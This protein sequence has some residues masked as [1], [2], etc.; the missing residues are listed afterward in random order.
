MKEFRKYIFAI[1]SALFFVLA[2]VHEHQT[3]N[4]DQEIRLI[5]TFQKA[6]I[7]QEAK[8]SNYLTQAEKKLGD[9]IRTG[10]YA[11]AFS[12]LNH[13]FED[14]GLGFMIFE[15]QKMVYW[16]SNQFAF[17]NLQGKFTSPN[18]LLTLPNGIYAAQKRIV[19]KY[20]LVGLVLLKHNYSYENQ[21]LENDYVEPFRLPSDFKLVPT[22]EK[23]SHEIHDITNQYLFSII[24]LGK[25]LFSQ[26]RL[27]LTVFLY[28]LGFVFMLL[29]VYRQI[30]QYRGEPFVVRMLVVLVVLFIIYWIH[31]IFGIP[32]ILKHIDIFSAQYYAVSKWLPSLGDFFLIVILIFFW[33]LAFVRE[34]S[35]FTSL[36]RSHVLPAFV[37][38]G[39]LYQMVG[40]MIAN[41][42]RNSN[43]AYKLN[44]ITDIGPFS[45][46][47]Y[48][49]IAMLLFSV[50][51][52]HLKIIEKTERLIR[53]KF[54]L[55]VHLIA[56]P[57]SI[58][59]CFLYPSGGFYMLTLF[60]S[61]NLLHYQVQKMHISLYSLSYS[62]LFI[63]LFSVVSLLVVYH[64][65]KKRD[66][67]IQKVMAINL[68]SEQDPVAE[69]FLARIQNQFNT[70]SV[71]PK[72]LVPPYIDLENYLIRTYFSGYFRK[73]DI[74]VT[75]CSS[76]DS[77]LIK[78]ENVSEPC[79]PLL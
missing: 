69:V 36:K 16:S 14:E 52:I 9:S 55:H 76:T 6:L 65:I 1:L 74:Q 77:V 7:G 5:Q 68:S 67:Q 78:P 72:L 39:M 66:V 42:I 24:P 63:S 51:L 25:K 37:F 33:S 4:K 58:G 34:L 38:A 3:L 62:I 20:E 26:T 29:T 43:I 73:Y 2:V 30:R 11:S 22:H 59:L 60:L 41:L 10:N 28:L 53:R 50:F 79:F 31:I 13:L 64:T 19:G 71:I 8:L 56:V 18:Q 45:V 70:D 57:V 46:S 12:N 17:P 47:S 21:Y 44:Q 32:V 54:F 61:V 40:F 49:A 35:L 27:Y 75:F 23:N 15:G 48:L